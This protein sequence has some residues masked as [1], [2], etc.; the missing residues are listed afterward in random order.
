MA[1]QDLTPQLRT[2]LSRMERAV[3]WFVI[4]ATLLLVIGFGYYIYQTAKNKGWFKTKAKYFTFVD[5]AAGLK[6]GDPVQLLGSDAGQITDI[7]PMEPRS[8]YNVYV[9]FELQEPNFGY[10]WTSGS[11]ARVASA[12]F[13]G[14]RTIEVIK[15]AGG[16]ATYITFPVKEIALAEVKQFA[17]GNW[18]VA[19]DIYSPGSTQMLA[20]A[21]SP[22]TNLNVEAVT[23]LGRTQICILDL[24]ARKK[25]LTAQWNLHDHRYDALT[26]TTKPYWLQVDESPALTERLEIVVK[27]VQ[28]ALPNILGLTNLLATV[29]SN[30][31]SLTSNLNVV[32]ISA[33]PAVSNLTRLTSQL[34]QPGAL[35]EWLLPTNL[36]QKL[37]AVLGGADTALT[38][39]NT[40]LA[41]L[42]QNLNRSLENLAD[43]TSNLN[44]QVQAN[45][46]I[47][48]N[49]SRAVI[50]ADNLVQGL[51]QHWLLR[52]AFKP[53]VTNKPPVKPILSPRQK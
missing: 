7:K 22:L 43:I 52:S 23:S 50:D 18:R 1:L 21:F 26:K 10:M 9:E 38:T 30:S 33:Q 4:L 51:K 47:L 36:N 42:A 32:A 25:F 20:R 49:I 17:E 6:I 44:S 27:Q 39:A 40:N 35:G 37:D 12:D 45:T 19:E 31:A 2:R 48:A 24:G 14:K 8:P 13:L 3:G 53:G 28:E 16:H 5:S 15:G 41:V 34:N 11:V 29:L 46:N